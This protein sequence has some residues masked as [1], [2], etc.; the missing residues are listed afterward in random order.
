M[1]KIKII[2]NISALCLMIFMMYVV[3]GNT[4][5]SVDTKVI[6]AV[7]LGCTALLKLDTNKK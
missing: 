4:K 1:N 5:V 7:I 3:L 6:I 2:E